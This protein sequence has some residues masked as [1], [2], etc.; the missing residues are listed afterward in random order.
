MPMATA[1]RRQPSASIRRCAIGGRTIAPRALPHMPKARAVAEAGVEPRRDRARV[2]HLRR[3]HGDQAEH[4]EQRVEVP[5]VR[6]QQRDRGEGRAEDHD[7]RQ[8]DAARA[9]AVEQHPGQRR[10]H[11]RGHGGDAERARDRLAVPRERLRDRLEEDAERVDQDRGE[12]D[13]HPERRSGGD[14]PPLVAGRPLVERPARSRRRSWRLGDTRTPAGPRTAAGAASRPTRMRPKLAELRS[15]TGR[16]K[17]AWLARLKASARNCSRAS[18]PVSANVPDQ[19]QIDVGEGRAARDVAAG[20]AELPGL[21]LR[22]EALERRAADPLVDG[23]RR[24]RSDRRSRS[25]G[26]PAK[27]E[28]GGLLACSATLA[29]SDTVNGVPELCVAIDADLPAAERSR[30]SA[31]RGVGAAAAAPRSR[32]RRS[33]AARRTATARIP[34]AGR[35]GSARDRSRR[36]AAWRRRPRGSSPTARRATSNTSTTR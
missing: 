26:W 36:R 4:H 15:A 28:I 32:W 14:A 31:A 13:Q 2:G 5:Q 22:I 3:G 33:D 18:R 27:P 16:P 8:D 34:P 11:R 7:R 29:V 12:A 20:V 6:R 19:R 25:A 24:R 1:A 9:E 30:C 35:T 23:A 17:L 10:A 21:R